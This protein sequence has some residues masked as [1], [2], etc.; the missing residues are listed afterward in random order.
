MRLLESSFNP[1]APTMLQ[2]IEQGREIILEK[3]NFTLFNGIVS[4]K[5]LSTFD[6]A[7]SHEDLKA[8][9]KW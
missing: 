1:D 5:E 8:R 7:W 4:D 6:Q 3:T 9:R 2:N